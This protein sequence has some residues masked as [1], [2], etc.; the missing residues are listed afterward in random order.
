MGRE[1]DSSGFAESGEFTNL[2]ADYGVERGGVTLV[3]ARDKDPA[4]TGFIA[5][6]YT[7]MLGRKFDQDG[8]NDWCGRYASG[9]T[10]EE[11]EGL[12]DHYG[13]R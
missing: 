4:A 3:Q 5:R 12:K 7:K 11:F 13:V 2:C 1:T 9:E 8:L 6:L 10:I